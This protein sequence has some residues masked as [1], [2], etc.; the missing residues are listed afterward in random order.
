MKY[1][2]LRGQDPKDRNPTETHYN[3]LKECDDMWTMLFYNML[4]KDDYG[5]IWYWGGKRLVKYAPNFIERRVSQFSNWKPTFE[6]DIILS[7]G[8]FNEY[9]S[10]MAKFPSAFKIYYGAHAKRFIPKTPYIR[11]NLILVDSPE[12]CL[13]VKRALPT[14]PVAM[15]IKPAADNIIIPDLKAKKEYDVVFPANGTQPF[16]GHQF[17][18]DTVP[19]DLKLLHLGFPFNYPSKS[20]ITSIRVLRK[21][22]GKMYSK[23]KVG[24]VCPE[25]GYDSCP[26]VI[27]ELMLCNVPI[28]VT[29]AT[30]FWKDM[31]MNF[32]TGLLVNSR[33]DIWPA[34]RHILK[35]LDIY[36]PANHYN[37][38]LSLSKAS[39]YLLA[40]IENTKKG[41]LL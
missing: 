4:T 21:N 16:K 35:N 5:E 13:L 41:I 14:T 29:K 24:I 27:P 12:Q 31:Y 18:F 39:H 33:E 15:L 1:L 10:V 6:P 17:I 36:K 32:Y 7:R 34:V 30:N 26:R 3:S 25:A 2:F 38:Y 8:G 11:Y 22:I 37:E 23:A 20:N 40:L 9:E 19:K 28:I